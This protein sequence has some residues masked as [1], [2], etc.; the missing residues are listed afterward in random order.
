MAYDIPVYLLPQSF[1]PFDFQDEAGQQIDHRIRKIFPQ[2]KLIC[3]REAEGYSALLAHY[4]LEHNTIL[5]EDMVLSSRIHDYSVAMKQKPDIVLPEITEDCMCLI[6]NVRAC[7]TN[8]EKTEELYH[9][10]VRKGIACGLTVYITYHSTQDAELCQK[11]KS[12]FS[13]EAKVVLLDHDYSCMEFNELVKKFRFVVGSRFHALVHAL[14]NGV[15]C[16]AMGWAIKYVDL[17]K[18]FGQNA[19][20]LDLRESVPLDA[21]QE[22]VGKMAERFTVEAETIREQLPDVQ[23]ENVFDKIGQQQQSDNYGRYH[24]GRPALSPQK[25]SCR[26]VG[27]S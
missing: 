27:D 11:L 22:A 10:A 1:G 16:V 26:C 7:E 18:L 15:P 17:M 12:D 25:R 5:T 19:Y 9:C 14:K 6:P 23:R 24:P 20:M 3:A 13:D 21:V 2:V 8:R 4:K